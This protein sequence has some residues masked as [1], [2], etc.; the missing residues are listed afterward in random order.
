MSGVADDGGGRGGKV[1]RGGMFGRG[2]IGA[3]EYFGGGGGRGEGVD[4][5]EGMWSRHAGEKGEMEVRRLAGGMLLEHVTSVLVP[6]L[7]AYAD[8][9]AVRKR[10]GRV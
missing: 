9:D 6:A 3:D 4:A 8:A 10:E 5:L 2:G 1:G 7:A